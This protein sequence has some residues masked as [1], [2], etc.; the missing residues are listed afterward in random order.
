MRK[1]DFNDGFTTETEPTESGLPA[2]AVT[3]TP[4][5]NLSSTNVQAALNEL[6]GDAD[7][8]QGQINDITDLAGV[9][10]GLA[11]LDSNGKVPTTQMP[12]LALTDVYVVADIAARDALTVQEGDVAKVTDAGAGTTKTF[13]YDGSSWVELQA[14]GQLALHEADTSA[15]GVS[16]DLLGTTD[17]QVITN[18]DIDG[19][20]ASNTSRIT[21]PKNTK[22]NLDGLT[23]KEGTL[24]YA[25]DQTKAYVDNGTAL[26]PVG[27]GSGSGINHLENP[28]AETD[29]SGYVVSK[30]TSASSTPD[31]GFVTSGTT[32]TWTRSTSS[33]LREDA[34]FVLTKS[35]GS[36]L[37][38]Q[39]STA[40]TI[41]SADQG[42]IQ[43]I[44]G[45]Y[46][47]ESGT[48]ATGDLT[49]WVYDVTNSR[50]IQPSSYSIENVG[51]NG[52]L[53]CTF[54]ASID[55]LSYKLVFHVSSSSSSAYSLKFD[56]LSIGPQVVSV[57]AVGIIGEI[58][59]TGST[60]PPQGYL[61]CNGQ[62]V[63]RT[64]YSDLFAAIGVKFG[65]GDGSTTF[66]VPDFR[67]RFLRGTSDGQSTDPDRAS[68]TAMNT[69]GATGDNVGSVQG[70]ATKRPNTSFV[71]G[72]ESASHTHAQTQSQGGTG[73]SYLAAAAAAWSAGNNAT[74]GTQSA[75]HTHTVTSGGD[76]ETRP[77]N[78]NVAYHI[79]FRSTA[80]VSTSVTYSDDV[81]S[82]HAF[83]FPSTS[84]PQGYL[85][86][87]GTAV[88]RTAY[89]DLFTKIG[90]TFGV[91][92][93]STTFN[94]PDL[95]GI[96]IRG[97]GSQ[98][99]GGQTFTGVL[100]TK[101]GDST[102][103]PNSAFTTDSQGAHTHTTAG[104]S[105]PTMD[106]TQC[107][108]GANTGSQNLA[109]PTTSSGAHTHTVTGGGDSET[110]P[111]NIGLT[112]FIKFVKGSTAQIQA[113]SVIACSYTKA[114]AQSTTSAVQATVL[115]DT[116]RF[117]THNAFNTG[118]GIFTVPA[119]G[120]YEVTAFVQWA[121]HT[122]GLDYIG[123]N[124]S[125]L[126]DCAINYHTQ[127]AAFD[128]PVSQI[129]TLIECQ[130]GQT[131]KIIV[132]QNSG[133]AVNIAPSGTAYNRID[134]KRLGGM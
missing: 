39:V 101:T 96:F 74:T 83:A 31:S 125:V 11:T 16:G 94:L 45:D 100:G 104:T 114:A 108:R 115:F 52:K 121:S 32:I 43:S 25:T 77:K 113:S 133:G 49:V 123:V 64:T 5:G 105:V 110:A 82:V 48:Y 66:H 15:H 85:A 4:S 78:A 38:E 35:S 120:I 1:L 69:G 10:D 9:P 51:I 23:R 58:I 19:G 99:I 37:G 106:G 103:R 42:E 53:R 17:A 44:L 59:A 13:I 50:W 61:Y 20:T 6:Q 117:D 131:L 28:I 29:A 57:A 72:T 73:G 65:S 67:G 116:K 81:G 80:Q 33:P 40:F 102:A 14:D 91:G 71:T 87:D 24:V 68:R 41:D 134:I 122:S 88:S 132:T 128:K 130:A 8:L 75:N 30:N 27:S 47:V 97:A 107:I 3:N 46:K 34:S 129:T 98:V 2:S 90:T 21:L 112:Y 86:A 127:T 79:C 36:A 60:T 12:A 89:F 124:H 54:Q 55:S 70:D 62:T 26:I 7:S 126:G 18:K 22:A 118:T 92:D 111:A 84:P 93:G 63:S 109:L 119:P 56:N 95:R 76:N